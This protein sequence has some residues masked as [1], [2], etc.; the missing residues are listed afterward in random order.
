MGRTPQLNQIV[1]TSRS[2][3]NTLQLALES[4][5]M[6]TYMQHA[7]VRLCVCRRLQDGCAHR[8]DLYACVSVGNCRMGVLAG[9]TCMPVCL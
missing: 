6:Q 3:E 2:T 4:Y 1:L 7:V 8:C 5:P 9:V